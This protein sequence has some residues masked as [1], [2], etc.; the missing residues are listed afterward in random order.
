MWKKSPPT[1]DGKNYFVSFI[2]HYS[3][4]AVVYLMEN[5]SEV[6]VHFRKYV[7]MVEAKFGQKIE[8][9]RCDNGGEY[10]SASFKNFCESK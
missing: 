7:S 1:H 2:D 3:R 4:F 8:N 9:L 10:I 5:K 6:E